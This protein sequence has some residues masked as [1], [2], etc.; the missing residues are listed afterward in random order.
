VAALHAAAATLAIVGLAVV[1]VGLGGLPGSLAPKGVDEAAAAQARPNVVVVMTDD[2]HQASMSVMSQTRALIGA[3]GTTFTNSFVNFPLCC[4]SRATYLTGQYAHNH[5]VMANTPP[6]GGFEKLDSSNTLPVWLQRAGYRTAHVGKYLNGYGRQDPVLVPPG[7]SE[8]YASV[9]G[10]VYN[11]DLNENGTIVHHGSAPGDFKGDVYT[12]KAVDFINRRAGSDDPFFL[13][14]GYAAPHTSAGPACPNMAEPAPRHVGEFADEPLPRPP[15]FNEADV[16]DKPLQLQRPRIGESGIAE[17]TDSYRC[18]LES[19][20]H[21]DEGVAEI[22]DALSQAGELDQTYV[23]FTS[24]NGY[25]H[26]EHRIRNNKHFLYEESIRVPLLIRGPGIP[27]DTRITDLAINAD[28]APTIADAT[29]A[30]PTLIEDGISLLDLLQGSAPD[31][32]LLIEGH[33]IPDTTQTYAAVR[34]ERYIYAEH[35]SGARELYD[36]AADPFELENRHADPAYTEIRQLLATRLSALRDCTG[37]S[38]LLSPAPPPPPPP[39]GGTGPSPP[40][41]PPP[42][43]GPRPSLTLDLEAKKQELKKKIKF[44]ATASVTSTLVAESKKTKDT[45]TQ[46]VASQKTKIKAKLKRKARNRLE[47]KLDEK[48]RAKVKIA[49]TATTQSGAEATDTVKVKLKD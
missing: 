1:A 47:E 17:I 42:N 28:L 30:N 44:F 39:N 2:Q 19:L 41:P 7:W 8:W 37:Q 38:C 21:V 46:L 43:G 27:S 40:P 16:S 31:R 24:D 14:V 49:G 25:F 15:S 48:G 20:L 10:S 23:I 26:G 22:V 32:D 36:L 3:Q 35:S 45:E 9:R 4:P 5:G 13:S 29:G 33:L 34:T 18:R 6:E 12:R 11:Y